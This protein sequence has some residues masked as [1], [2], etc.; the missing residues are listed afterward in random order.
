MRHAFANLS[1]W[2]GGPGSNRT[3][4]NAP[5]NT[6]GFC[7]VG[8]RP[9]RGWARVRCPSPWPPG[10]PARRESR[11]LTGQIRVPL[12]GNRRR[13]NRRLVRPAPAPALRRPRHTVRTPKYLASQRRS[14]IGAVRALRRHA[15]PRRRQ[16]RPLA[17]A[18]TRFPLRH[19]ALRQRLPVVH[20]QSP[21]PRPIHHRRQRA[22][23]ERCAPPSPGRQL[24][25]A[26]AYSAPFRRQRRIPHPATHLDQPPPTCRRSRKPLH[27]PKT[28]AY[29]TS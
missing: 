11:M 23:S 8:S 13:I 15:A 4:Q 26:S 14:T 2:H 1:T 3:S 7:A 5:A 6:D 17:A 18:G 20:R 9:T 24:A 19:R 28:S 22:L 25:R 12:C 10:S 27:R 16:W 29:S 21:Q